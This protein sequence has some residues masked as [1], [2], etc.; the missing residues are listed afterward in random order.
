MR[1]LIITQYFWPEEF[2]INDFAISFQKRGHEICVLT[3]IPNY[4]NGSFYHSYGLFKPKIE[5]YNNIKIIRTILYPRGNS[6]NLKLSINYVS[7]AFFASL[8]ALFRIKSKFDLVFVYQTSPITVGIPAIVVKKMQHI[9]IFFWV[10]DLWPESVHAVS[11]RKSKILNL[12]LNKLVKFIYKHCEM[13]F[14]PSKAFVKSIIEKDIEPDKIQYVP[15]WAEYEYLNSRNTNHLNYDNLFPDAGFKIMFAGNL[16]EAQD[17]E[18]ILK[19]AEYVRGYKDIYWI[20]IGDGRKRK[21]I[22]NKIEE[23]G[24]TENILLLGR[25]PMNT[26]SDFFS[27]ADV[28]IITLKDEYIFSLTVPTKLQSYMA[29]GK[30]IVAMIN[31][32]TARIIDEAGA[33]FTCNS[34]D[35]LAFANKILK[36]YTMK[37]EFRKIM[38][39]NSKDYYL[40]NYSK[41]KILDQI[42]K[43]FFEAIDIC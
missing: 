31:G 35:S 29:C 42:E 12:L 9:P 34:G 10:Q 24:L 1:I 11:Y 21:W 18:S 16:G 25:Y 28:M 14:V 39:T 40:S 2:K 19:A 7:F 30:P 23:I 3:G 37:P 15:N 13:I 26:M 38:G 5:Y 41:E 8:A 17:F 33:G 20:I 43:C 27:K 32:E 4:P 36:M 22:E 6:S